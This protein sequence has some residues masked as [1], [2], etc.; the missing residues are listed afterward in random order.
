MDSLHG[1]LL[2]G[3][4]LWQKCEKL[5]LGPNEFG[6]FIPIRD[7]STLNTTSAPR[8]Y[9][10]GE[11]I[12]GTP[13]KMAFGKID[14][15][16]GKD[17]AIT[18]LTDEIMAD[19][20]YIQQYVINALKGRLG[21][22]R[23]YNIL[24]GTYAAGTQGLTGIFG[25]TNFYTEPVAHAATYTGAI[26]NGIISGVDPRLRA[27]SEW[28]MSN[29]M[30]ATLIGQLGT[31]TTVSTQP[32]FSNDGKTLAGYPV[33]VMT[34]MAAF[35]SAGD[36]LFGNFSQYAVA[37]RGDIVLSKS[38]EYSFLT[39][40]VV[41]KATVRDLGAP[42]YRKYTPVDARVVAAFSSTSGT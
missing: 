30:H 13:T 3:S 31:G 41:I 35:G 1:E 25:A 37:T 2:L 10:P 21:W 33:N 19:V 11:G 34:Q 12:S 29:S 14:L 17:M 32:I 42:T 36:I 22:N 24:N 8:S 28:Y 18:Y 27:G 5:P 20:G 9:N 4:V 26:V 7:E 38:E 15:K 40:E 39:D 16:L 23:D 6:R